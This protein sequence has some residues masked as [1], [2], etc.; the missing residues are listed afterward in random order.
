MKTQEIEISKL[1]PYEFNNRNH[2]EEQVNR[3]ANSIK[4]FGFNQ[5]IVIDESNIILVG[6]GRHLAALKLGLKEVPV[7]IKSGLSEAQKK[8]YR[9]LDNKLQ[10]D[11]T[12]SF[13]NLE[14]ELGFLEDNGF[15]LE[16]WGLDELRGLFDQEDPEVED[17]EFDE[18][19]CENDETFIK[20]GD[21]IELG[22]HKL[23]CIDCREA[24]K[25]PNTADMWITD[26]PYGVS[27]VGKT[28]DALT[29]ENDALS[30]EGTAELWA[31]ATRYALDNLKDGGACYAAVPPGPLNFIF[32]KEWIELLVIHQQLVWA[33]D[34]MVLGH[35]DYHYK[36]EP[37]L[38]GWKPGGSHYFTADRTK[39]SILDFARP[40]R[41]EEHP[42]MK[43][44]ELWAELISNS[45]KKGDIVLDTFLGSGTTLI[46]SDQLGRI[47]YGMEISP[48]Y[49]HVIIE[50]YKKHCEK[51]GKPFVCKINGEPYH[52]TTS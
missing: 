9:I 18:S 15:E 30:E 44:V 48:K 23:W 43:P 34:S 46:A 7:L 31:G 36:H 32:L 10:N 13:D 45:S 51:V 24:D 14:L 47:C 38:Y 37:I 19:E 16:P 20:L 1:I 5:P 28:K 25:L 39:T 40:K 27:Y 12:W 29:I 11:S 50:R 6:H 35:S 3:I 41:S 4:E 22:Q 52:G 21:L 26:P 2:N 17:D 33:K 49:C 42:T 8:A